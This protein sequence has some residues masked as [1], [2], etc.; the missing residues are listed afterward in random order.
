MQPVEFVAPYC[1]DK[2]IEVECT[3]TNKRG[4]WT[5]TPPKMV[6]IRRS[7]DTLRVMC[8][9]K[10]HGNS[11]SSAD[12][13]MGSKLALSF[14]FID[15]GIVDAITDKHR[16]YP[17]QVVLDACRDSARPSAAEDMD[18]GGEAQSE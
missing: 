4:S 17:D 13:R 15:F 11:I 8:N 7:D 9:A 5:F 16:I 14:A 6:K 1:E 3:A 10:G 12:S 2:V 18:S